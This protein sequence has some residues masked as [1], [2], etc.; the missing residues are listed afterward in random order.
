LC[1][2]KY[3]LYNTQMKKVIAAGVGGYSF[4][5]EEDAYKLLKDYLDQFRAKLGQTDDKNEV[6]QD[7]EAR[8]AEL[9]LEEIKSPNQVVGHGLL[10]R[11]VQQMG[12]PDGSN[13][14]TEY[15]KDFQNQQEE[16][17]QQRRLFRDED[18]RVIGGVL[19]GLSYYLEIDVVLLRVLTLIALVFAGAGL[20]LYVI[21]WICVPVAHTPA[22]KLQMRG[23]P[24]T[25][26][27]LLNF[28]QKK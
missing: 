15:H 18:N 10:F 7:I 23:I 14:Y 8:I 6:M 25:A 17:R 19:S 2:E 1:I 11:I 26:E 22:Q 4:Q 5:L 3:L 13:D 12:M 27:N 16:G 24:V 20:W 21:F 9:L 28:S